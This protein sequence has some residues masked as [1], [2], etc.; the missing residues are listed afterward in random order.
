M[1]RTRAMSI[2]M[3]LAVTALAAMAIA[4]EAK[5]SY[6]PGMWSF[7]IKNELTGMPFPIPPL[8]ME[9][10]I[11]DKDVVPQI[12]AAGA[13]CAPITPKITGNTVEWTMDCKDKNGVTI[14]GTGKATYSPAGDSFEGTVDVEVSGTPM[15]QKISG[16]RLGDCAKEEKREEKPEKREEKPK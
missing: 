13:D 11:T 1:R 12:Q 14:K 5:L 4:G 15:K 6:K 16:K 7:T 8:T 2:F 3:I 9:K 10:C